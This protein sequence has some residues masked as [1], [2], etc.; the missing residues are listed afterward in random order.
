MIEKSDSSMSF[1]T[2]V[3]VASEFHR[4]H[5]CQEQARIEIETG[6]VLT[7]GI[8][9]R[10]AHCTWTITRQPPGATADI[11]ASRLHGA[12]RPGVYSLLCTTDGRWTRDL[13]VCCFTARQMYEDHTPDGQLRLRARSWINDPSR[14]TAE[15]IQRLETR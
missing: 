3:I 2:G 10:V 8:A 9:P 1:A 11:R 6:E 14:T 5:A 15:I 4:D 7:L 13:D 12:T